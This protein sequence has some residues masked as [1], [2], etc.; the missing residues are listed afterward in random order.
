MIWRKSFEEPTTWEQ[1]VKERD[2]EIQ[3]LNEKIQK[4]GAGG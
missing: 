3:R 1:R 2:E 4:M